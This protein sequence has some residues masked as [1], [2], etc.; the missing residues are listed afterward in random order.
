MMINVYGDAA[1]IH[2]KHQSPPPVVLWSISS[3]CVPCRLLEPPVLRQ[4]LCRMRDARGIHAYHVRWCTGSDQE[5]SGGHLDGTHETTSLIPESTVGGSRHHLA[6]SSP[7]RW[8]CDPRRIHPLLRWMCEPSGKHQLLR[9]MRDP[10]GKHPLLWR[11][12]EP[13]GIHPLL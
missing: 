6:S 3:F 5:R 10:S 12:C 8:M 1:L 9:W 4:P 11:M 13:S 2:T 7:L